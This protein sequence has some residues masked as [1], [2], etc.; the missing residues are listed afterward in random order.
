MFYYMHN[1]NNNYQCKMCR[2]K[3]LTFGVGLKFRAIVLMQ[4]NIMHA[5][6]FSIQMLIHFS[7]IVPRVCTLVLFIHF[8]SDLEKK[9]VKLVFRVLDWRCAVSIN[10]LCSVRSDQFQMAPRTSGN[11]YGTL[12]LIL[13]FQLVAACRPFTLVD[14]SLKV[15]AALTYSSYS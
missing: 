13:R 5:K 14:P 1:N 9:G 11:G 6:M 3:A 12:Q 10:K 2:N 4:Y 8:G 15:G 7:Q